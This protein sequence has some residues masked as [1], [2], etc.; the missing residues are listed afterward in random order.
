MSK[1]AGFIEMKRLLLPAMGFPL[2]AVGKLLN[3]EKTFPRLN[4]YLH[5][6]VVFHDKYKKLPILNNTT[7]KL[8]CYTKWLYPSWL[9]SVLYMKQKTCHPEI[10]V[11]ILMSPYQITPFLQTLVAWYLFHWGVTKNSFWFKKLTWTTTV[12]FLGKSLYR[13]EAFDVVYFPGWTVSTEW[14][15]LSLSSLN[16][17]HFW[18]DLMFLS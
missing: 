3:F 8:I 1:F 17:Q 9:I 18:F 2:F 12:S 13:Y 4:L 16:I 7:R 5:L 10:H 6:W 15:D 14:P 11:L